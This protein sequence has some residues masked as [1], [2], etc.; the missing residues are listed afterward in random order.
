MKR[1]QFVMKKAVLSHPEFSASLRIF[2]SNLDFD[3]ISHRLEI[4]PTETHRAGDRGASSRE[5]EE[6]FWCLESPL[7]RLKPLN[8]HVLWLRG[9]LQN[10]RAFL[11]TVKENANVRSFCSVN[12]DGAHC[13]FD[14]TVD[15]LRFFSELELNIELSTIFGGDFQQNRELITTTLEHLPSDTP[16]EGIFLEAI[17]RETQAIIQLQDLGFRSSILQGG[18][19][20]SEFAGAS[21]RWFLTGRGTEALDLDQQLR[22]INNFLS[23]YTDIF[24]SIRETTD[25]VIRC[26]QTIHHETGGV[27]VFVGGLLEPIALN[28]PFHFDLTLG[29]V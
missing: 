28:I 11:N 18:Q 22:E 7:S 26:K 14:L 20:D 3:L 1:V 16:V 8:D 10:R 27:D 25:L 24:R 12:T 29:R 13:S 9:M 23:K 15:A 5:Y 6:D 21:H 4:Q 19:L 2:G 17:A